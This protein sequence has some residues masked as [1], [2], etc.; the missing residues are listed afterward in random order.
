MQ[1][2]ATDRQQDG[3]LVEFVDLVGVGEP[4]PT[5]KTSLIDDHPVKDVGVLVRQ[6]VFNDAGRFAVDI[7][8]RSPLLE[9]GVRDAR[10]EIVHVA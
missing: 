6:D 9:G 3:T 2:L 4:M 1:L 8:Y 10:P 5:G 7:P